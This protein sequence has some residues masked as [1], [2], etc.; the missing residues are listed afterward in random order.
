MKY[1]KDMYVVCPFY[2]REDTEIE[3]KLHCEGYCAGNHIHMCFDNKEL[4]KEHKKRYC[5][6]VKGYHKCPIYPAIVRK[7]KGGNG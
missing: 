4:I 6:N 1:Y 7:Y 5:K 2:S 3:R